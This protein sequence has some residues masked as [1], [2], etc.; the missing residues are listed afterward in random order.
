MLFQRIHF[1]FFFLIFLQADLPFPANFP[2]TTSDRNRIE[3]GFGVSHALISDVNGDN[4]QDWVI[5][6]PQEDYGG[7]KSGALY[8]VMSDAEGGMISFV[9]ITGNSGN[10]VGQMRY[11]ETLGVSVSRLSPFAI[12]DV[13]CFFSQTTLK[14]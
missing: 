9:R 3:S 10:F 12:N 1:S 5:G 4:I 8:L 2:A 14:F 7:G 13:R 11:P 6:S